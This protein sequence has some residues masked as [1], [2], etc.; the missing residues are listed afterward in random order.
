ME[1]R[2]RS[3][4]NVEVGSTMHSSEKPGASPPPAFLSPLSSTPLSDGGSRSDSDTTKRSVNVAPACKQCGGN[5]PFIIR[6]KGTTRHILSMA[7]NNYGH[8]LYVACIIT[9]IGA[10]CLFLVCIKCSM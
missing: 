5:L 3:I 2:V 8:A 4:S 1:R 6:G 10:L 7:S 9:F